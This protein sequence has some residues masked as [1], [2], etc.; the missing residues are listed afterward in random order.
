[1][2]PV[3]RSAA[4]QRYSFAEYVELESISPVRH[5]FLDGHVWA[6]TGGSPDHA[7]IA[8]NVSSLLRAALRGGSCRVFSSDLRIRVVET[9]LGTYPDVS[10]VCGPLE[11]DAA[12]PRGHTVTNPVLVVEVLSPS[13]EDYDR[14]EKLAAFKRIASLRE[15]VL[16]AHDERRLEIWRRVG[17]IWTTE[18]VRGDAVA[19]LES[20]PCELPLGEVYE[21]A[22]V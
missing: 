8:V 6:M 7:A 20:V 5:E 13:T 3:T 15:V 18:I 14:G 9:G 19:R 2:V 11:L 12:D 17:A 1:V 16:V 10:V 21:G 22:A 4:K